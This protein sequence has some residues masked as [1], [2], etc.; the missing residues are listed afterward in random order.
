MISLVVAHDEHRLIGIDGDL[1]WRLPNDLAHFKRLTLGKIVLMGRKTWESLPKRPLPEREN[2]VLSRDA[3]FTAAGATVFSTLDAT[4][5]AAEGR[6]LVV[7]GGAELF[8]RTLPLAQT[9]HL[10]EVDSGIAAAQTG[11]VYFPE[12]AAT[13]Y[14]VTADELHAADA[15]HAHAYRFKTLQKKI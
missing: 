1:P 5:K 15:R 2:W 7:I 4:L 8:A 10:T 3:S 14:R 6:E 13:D 11:G 12:Y 9:I